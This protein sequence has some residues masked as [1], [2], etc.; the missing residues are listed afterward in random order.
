M[1]FRTNIIIAVAVGTLVPLLLTLFYKGKLREERKDGDFGA[2]TR[3]PKYLIVILWV[4]VSLMF[5]LFVIVAIGAAVDHEYGIS[6]GVFIGGLAL[7]TLFVMLLF[8]IRFCYDIAE[9]DK[10]VRIRRFGRKRTEYYYKDIPYFSYVEGYLGGLICYNKFGIAKIQISAL[11]VGVGAI[12]KKLKEC[13]LKQV[14][15]AVNNNINRNFGNYQTAIAAQNFGYTFPTE[16]MKQTPQYKAFDKKRK[17][18]TKTLVCL[19]LG[20]PFAMLTLMIAFLAEDPPVFENYRVDGNLESYE[21]KSE[22]IYF[23]LANDDN[24][25][26]INNIIIDEFNV[27]LFKELYAENDRITL[28]IGYTGS[29]NRKVISQVELRGFTLLTKADAEKAERDNAD[30]GNLIGW[31]FG[32]PSVAVLIVGIFFAIKHKID[33]GKNSENYKLLASMDTADAPEF[34]IPNVW[35]QRP[36]SPPSPEHVATAEKPES[37]FPDFDNNPTT[38]TENTTLPECTDA[39]GQSTPP[40]QEPENAQ[41]DEQTEPNEQTAPTTRPDSPE[42]TDSDNENK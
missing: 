16:Q 36:P 37:P 22:M 39:P 29:E 14:P 6:I 9:D 20:I 35:T 19:L 26:Y 33:F 31:V 41:P 4:L 42:P 2:R 5:V 38:Q 30:L 13:G 28:Y 1:D 11:T 23:K 34:N 27:A 40:E 12:A 21:E 25:Y 17:S 7:I 8:Y 15:M 32:V 3:T 18:L 24:V 10:I